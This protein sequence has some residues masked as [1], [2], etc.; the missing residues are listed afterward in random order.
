MK[1][2]KT[3]AVE[4]LPLEIFVIEMTSTNSKHE[5]LNP[6]QIQNSNVQI[7]KPVEVVRGSTTSSGK[8]KYKLEDL[9]GNGQIFGKIVKPHNHSVEA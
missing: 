9:R 5:I 1:N 4:Q 7:S 3:T 6:K 8:G 2:V